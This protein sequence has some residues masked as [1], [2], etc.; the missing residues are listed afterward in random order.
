MNETLAHCRA[1][2]GKTVMGTLGLRTIVNYS[3]G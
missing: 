3:K 2:R 1:V